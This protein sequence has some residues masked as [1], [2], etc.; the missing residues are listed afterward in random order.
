MYWI[1]PPVETTLAWENR[2][3]TVPQL[4]IGCWCQSK[5]LFKMVKL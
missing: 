2:N 5:P 1:F 3:Q 4:V